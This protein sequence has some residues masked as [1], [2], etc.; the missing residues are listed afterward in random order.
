M[1]W[2]NT[3]VEYRPRERGTTRVGKRFETRRNIHAIAKQVIALDHHVTEVDAYAKA[4]A[5][6]LSSI[7]IVSFKLALNIDRTAHGLDRARELG[8]NAVAS[9]TEHPAMMARDQPFYDVSVG[10]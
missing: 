4:H 5:P 6:V 9:A 10:A 3:D 8:D 2:S 1:T 7:D